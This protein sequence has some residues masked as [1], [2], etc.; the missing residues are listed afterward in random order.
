MFITHKHL[1]LVVDYYLDVKRTISINVIVIVGVF[2][3][4]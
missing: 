4:L 1:L 3:L 2:I